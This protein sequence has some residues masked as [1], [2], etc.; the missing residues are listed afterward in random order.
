MQ[1]FFYCLLYSV[2][3]KTESETGI[4]DLIICEYDIFIVDI[5]ILIVKIRNNYLL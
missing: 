4:F 5:I 3:R 2:Q 1:A